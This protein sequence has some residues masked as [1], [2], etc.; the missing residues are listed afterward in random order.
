MDD[1]VFLVLAKLQ[2][3][4]LRLEREQR[5]GAT[6]GATEYA[7]AASKGERETRR[8]PRSISDPD[9]RVQS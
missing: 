4:R 3:D 2:A 7:R 6:F 9:W 5:V 8:S 1:Y